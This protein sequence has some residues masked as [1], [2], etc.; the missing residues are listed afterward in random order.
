MFIPLGDDNPRRRFPLVTTT[1]VAANVL[2]YLF[3]QMPLDADA[4]Q[5]FVLRWGF[6]AADPFSVQA[7]TS[8]FLHGDLLHLLGNMWVFWILGDNVEEKFGRARFLFLYLL[9][10]FVATATYWGLSVSKGPDPEMI[11]LIGRG[12]PPAL[13]ASGAIYGVLGMYLVLFPWARI[14]T[15]LFFQI[16]GVPAIVFLGLMIAADVYRT[17]SVMGPAVGGVATAAHAGGGVFGI[18]AALVLKRAVGGGGEGSAWEVRT[19]FAKHVAPGEPAERQDLD[20]VPDEELAAQTGSRAAE[21]AEAIELFVTAGQ[22]KKA[23]ELYPEYL[24]NGGVPALA[25]DAELGIA[26]EYFRQGLARFAIP[27]YERFLRT[28]GIH[29][30]SADAAL[31]IAELYAQ[32]LRDYPNARR[33]YLRAAETHP[34]AEGRTYAWEQANRLR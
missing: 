4:G 28:S 24:R 8:M 27:S 20:V 14:R 30:R 11:E 31:R 13:G 18:L 17:L 7:F 25:P 19:G 15:I 29:P 22:P 26:D 21:L 34:E 9:A 23:L 1:L 5:A 32:N 2:V 12:Y 3:L 6:D 10:G 16:I 33:W